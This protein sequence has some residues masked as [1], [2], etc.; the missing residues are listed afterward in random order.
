[1]LG[2]MLEKNN[3]RENY[4][5]NVSIFTQPVQDLFKVSKI[6]VDFTVTIDKNYECK[7]IFLN[8]SQFCYLLT[9]A[10]LLKMLS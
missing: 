2:N 5:R 6:Q 9:K 3:L 1:M 10:N 7:Q 8:I 4:A